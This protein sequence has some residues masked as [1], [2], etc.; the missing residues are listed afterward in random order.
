MLLMLAGAAAAA[1][2]CH[3]SGR[4]AGA[5]AAAAAHEQ[6]ARKMPEARAAPAVSTYVCLRV[7]L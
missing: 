4:V 2:V 1:S 5:A 6:K 7:C 3:W